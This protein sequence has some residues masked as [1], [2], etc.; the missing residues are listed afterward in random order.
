MNIFKKFLIIFSLIALSGIRTHAAVETAQP[1]SHLT[2]T[3]KNQ[4]SETSSLNTLLKPWE[5]G[6]RNEL[7]EFEFENAELSSLIQYIEKKFS[8]T[9]ILDDQIS[10]LPAGGKSVLGTKISFRTHKPLTK[11]TA[12]E[13]FVTFLDMAGLGPVPGPR[14]GIYR[15]TT[16]DPASPLSINKS[17]LPSFIGVD[18]A[19]IPANDTRIRYVYFVENTSLDVIKNV[20]D[21]M[22]SSKAP[23]LIIFPELRAI[24]L[25]DKASNIKAI[26][27][28]V[29]ELD[30]V[31]M[32]ETLSI[33]KLRRT[34]ATKVAD[35]Y[36]AL[37]K[38]ESQQPGPRLLGGRKQPTTSYFPEGTRIIAEPRTN[39]LILLGNKDAIKKIETFIIKEI[40]K[41]LEAPFSPLHIYEL[42]Y[43]AADAIAA[44]L[45]EAIQ[46]QTDTEAAKYGGVRD[47]DKYFK[48]ISITPEK[49]GNRL[50]INADYEDYLKLYE[51]LQK[52]DVEQPQVAI[53][54][55]IMEVDLTD[56]KNFGV[57]MRNKVPGPNGLIGNH[58][59]YQT[60]GLAGLNTP[61]A[62]NPNGP[63]ATRL[64]G[65]L[66]SLLT[67]DTTPG[68]TFVTFGN[69]AFG[70]WGLFTV[71]QKLTNVSILSNPFL[72]TTHKYPASISLGETRRVLTG[73]SITPT[74]P[75]DSF[76]DLTAKLEVYI[77]PQISYE[78]FVIMNVRV[79][80]ETFTDVNTGS[81]NRIKRELKTS[82]IMAD[83]E[84]LALGGLL[85][86][87]IAENETKVPVL[88][89]IPLLGWLFKNKSK[90]LTK[91]SLLILITPEVIPSYSE[92]FAERFTNTKV[93]DAQTTLNETH[94]LNQTRDF[95]HRWFFK[96]PEDVQ[97]E[98]IDGFV[99]HQRR[100][101][102]P[103]QL[104]Q[105]E[106]EKNTPAKEK[107]K[108]LLTS[109]FVP[110]DEP[111]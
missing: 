74:G 66:V 42:K 25:T 101:I 34:D 105:P 47:G 71:L 94:S 75:V 27:E 72:V 31:N 86:N 81:G 62:E 60:S 68:A 48:P 106:E 61:V 59:T 1:E 26:L 97:A 43:V 5:F 102:D 16:N 65:N 21:A 103:S 100:Y 108:K 110:M 95:V 70:V 89:D 14:P 54:V 10:P 55:L 50:I 53:K 38:D 57:Q 64:L 12:W 93:N 78:G 58:T 52:I 30:R 45:K 40:D 63:G 69:D 98:I 107:P 20:I 9:F 39:T 3:K 33:I 15:I 84:T 8:L 41:E 51:I 17:A 90:T 73:T 7:I 32:P 46:F 91:T 76:D 4:D 2:T 77:E 83:N 79:N 44:I 104:V 35:L 67:N 36:K 22:K 13:I 24:M 111:V 28:V 49:G 85:R 19:L 18:P 56:T 109:N 29:R 99:T 87:D 96:D 92:K 80:L 88:G 23:N 37:V 82:V 6:D 11:K